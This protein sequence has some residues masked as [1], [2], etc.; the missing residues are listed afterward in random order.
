VIEEG[1]L[2]AAGFSEQSFFNLNTPQDRVAAEGG[3]FD[4]SS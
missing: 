1:E 3:D 2:A 4:S